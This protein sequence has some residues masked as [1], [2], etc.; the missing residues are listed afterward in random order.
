SHD[1]T[2][3]RRL[4]VELQTQVLDERQRRRHLHEKLQCGTRDRR[5]CEHLGQSAFALARSRPKQ[6]PDHRQVP[7]H[8]R[9]IRNSELAMAIENAEAP[10]AQHEDTRTW[11]EKA[12]E[13]NRQLAFFARES[14]RDD[15]NEQRGRDNANEHEHCYRETEQRTNR[16]SKAIGL[17]VLTASD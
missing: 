13:V 4:E 16:T 1:S 11:P 3:I 5:P 17:V 14:L 2:Y 8:R 10:S 15:G 7:Q 6:H 12:R 9:E